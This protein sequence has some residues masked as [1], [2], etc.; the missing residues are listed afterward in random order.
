[1]W[2]LAQLFVEETLNMKKGRIDAIKQFADKLADWISQKR[3]RN[4]YR[5]LTYEPPWEL[6]RRLLRAQREGLPLG[7]DEYATVWLH[8]DDTRAD[9]NLVRD[10]VCVRVVERLH[11]VNYF[12][13]HPE[14]RL[15]AGDDSDETA[16][17]EEEA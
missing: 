12:D 14:D 6:R 4:L 10:L 2:A 5:A 8:E 9:E 1:L 11:E 16:A 17:K 3:D 7:L 13:N 15:G